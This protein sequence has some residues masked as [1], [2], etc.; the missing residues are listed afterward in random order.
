LPEISLLKR[1]HKVPKT[2][3]Y[4]HTEFQSAQLYQSEKSLKDG[5]MWTGM[6]SGPVLTGGT[7]HD[8][9]IITS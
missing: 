7:N 9:K 2:E 3:F 8:K 1:Q 5:K 6:D 4:Q